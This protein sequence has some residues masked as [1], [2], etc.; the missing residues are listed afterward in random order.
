MAE[1]L[2]AVMAD[3]LK[4]F[5]AVAESEGYNADVKLERNVENG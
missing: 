3:A 5:Y 4:R 1:I 2:S